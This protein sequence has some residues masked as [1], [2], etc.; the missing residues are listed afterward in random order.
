M[1]TTRRQLHRGLI[2]ALAV[3]LP[4]TAAAALVLRPQ[5]P[6]TP[7]MPAPHPGGEGL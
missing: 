6:P 4:L 1:I 3:V 5:L 2:T 7:P